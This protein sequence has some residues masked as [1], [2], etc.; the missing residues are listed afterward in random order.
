[1]LQLDSE[2]S[3]LMLHPYGT[4]MVSATG[5]KRRRL[6][7]VSSFC[8]LLTLVI[9]TVLS[10]KALR[11]NLLYVKQVGDEMASKVCN[12]SLGEDE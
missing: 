9:K 2:L 11:A 4:L 10:R 7:M 1:M 12:P 3:V 5:M 8:S 6:Y